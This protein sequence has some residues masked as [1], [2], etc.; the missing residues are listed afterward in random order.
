MRLIIAEKPSVARAIATVIGNP[1]AAAG[2]IECE[3]GSVVT[4]AFGHLLRLPMPE[5]ISGGKIE[6]SDL[7]LLPA[8][9]EK[10]AKDKDA[11]K[12]LNVIRSLL[13]RADEAV[14][15]GDPDREG[16]LLID[17]ILQHAAWHGPTRRLW[18]SAVD[19]ASVKA[20]LASLRD[21]NDFANLSSS[22][23]CRSRADW[24]VGMNGSIALS[25]KI[26]AAGGAGALSIGRVQTP[27]LSL[28]VN[29]DAEIERFTKR[30][31]YIVSAIITGGIIARW[32]M[33]DDLDGLSDDGLLL[34]KS[35]AEA[36]AAR[37][38]GKPA[39]VTSYNIKS[40]S[41]PAPLPHSL[42]SLQRAASSKFGLSAKQTLAAAQSLCE[43]G[44]T[45]YPRSD[46]QYLPVEQLPAAADLLK[47]LASVPIPGSSGADPAH[48]HPA[49]DS[50]KVTA[51]HAIIPTGKMPGELAGDALKIYGLIAESYVRLFY[52]DEK[53]ETREACFDMDQLVFTARSRTTISP[54]WTQLAGA[55]A[56]DSDANDDAPSKSP[57]PPL[58]KNDELH[59]DS[60][61]IDARETKPPRRFND[62]SLIA[63]MTKVHVL[64]DDPKLK[65]RLKET[66][67]LGTEATRAGII[68][69][70]IA[71]GYAERRGKDIISTKKGQSVVAAMRQLYPAAI[72]P[73][74]TAVWE[75]ALSAVADG[76]T[77]SEQFMSAQAAQVQKMV[78]AIRDARAI[79]GMGPAPSK[80]KC[81][82][83]SGP[84]V[85][86]QTKKGFK[87]FACAG[88]DSAFF[89][90]KSGKP[91]D[92]LRKKG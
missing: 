11:E 42:S 78:T 63:A 74:V 58:Q 9:F 67:G 5:E 21:N 77:T 22:A 41:R 15:A 27:T 47:N 26:Q 4:W 48:R 56:D 39:I 2:Y 54:G 19:P 76:K 46:C 51:H 69:T 14:N 45:S 86:R 17:E 50:S 75:D 83:C 3:G 79:E 65:A 72:D 8:S 71:R 31:H 64:I 28:I 33:P 59:C 24:L 12:Q 90:D 37:I 6:M 57:L 20:A 92:R 43:S 7:P 1:R 87:F 91:G 10:I 16:Q 32:K 44:L 38:T 85:H 70:L 23:E 52:D 30:D 61:K 40:G 35:V 25:R 80:Y 88:C 89:V 34:D 82:D 68:E 66:S 13:S 73:G 62:G 29:R 55:D 60:A 18:L 36:V 49:W 81:A 84:L 53:Y